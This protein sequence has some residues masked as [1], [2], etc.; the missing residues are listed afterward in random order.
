MMRRQ[1][2]NGAGMAMAVIWP[3]S[4]SIIRTN[5]ATGTPCWFT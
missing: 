3:A 5:V 1:H 4:Y 2:S